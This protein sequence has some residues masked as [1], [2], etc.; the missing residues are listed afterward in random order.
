MIEELWSSLIE[1]SEQF[2]VPDWEALVA[3]IPIVLAVLVFLYL[4]WMIYRFAD[5]GT[6]PARQ[7]PAD[8]R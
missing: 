1:F 6:D 3:L 5:G 7:A 2:V 4:V 8:R